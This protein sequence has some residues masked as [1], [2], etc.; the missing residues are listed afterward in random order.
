[1]KPFGIDRNMVIHHLKRVPLVRDLV[2]AIQNLNYRFEGHAFGKKSYGIKY[3][4]FDLISSEGEIL[5]EELIERASSGDVV[6][7]VGANTGR[8]SLP[9]ATKGCVV[10]SFE[11]HPKIYEKFIKNVNI[12]KNNNIKP[13]NKGLS[14]AEEKLTFYQS[15][16]PGR[17]SFNKYN[18]E[19]GDAEIISEITITVT[20]ID[21]LVNSGE[22]PPPSHIKIDVEGAGLEVLRGARD[23]IGNYNP[24]IYF[25]PHE[26]DDNDYR[27]NELQT[28]FEEMDYE[29]QKFDYPWLCEPIS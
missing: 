20:T 17:S 14:D 11:P 9:L 27:T 26:V 21:D 24:V 6:F 10:C 29:I 15:S 22:V 23:T 28:F 16:Q 8:Y 2:M 12:N 18:A 19:Y 4:S 25:E 13:F 5:L 7:D 3:S 1:M